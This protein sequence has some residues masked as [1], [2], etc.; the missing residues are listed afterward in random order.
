[1]VRA[2]SHSVVRGH[3]PESATGVYFGT[4]RT[5]QGIGP[6]NTPMM[7]RYATIAPTKIATE[8]VTITNV[9][10]GAGRDDEELTGP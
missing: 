10:E 8:N 3:V 4:I 1:M 6:P 5:R 7:P 9:I 2:G